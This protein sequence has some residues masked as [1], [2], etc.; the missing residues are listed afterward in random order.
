MRHSIPN[1]KKMSNTFSI[2]T[3]RNFDLR[4]AIEGHGWY[5]LSPFEYHSDK[6][7]LNYVFNMPASGTAAIS[8][9]VLKDRIQITSS[10]CARAEA[11]HAVRHI[12]RMDEDL[13][14]FYSALENGA[15]LGWVRRICAGRLLRSVTVFEDLVKTLCTT[16]CSWSLT[17]KM[18]SNLVELLGN[19]APN[20]QKAFPTPEA[21]AACSFDVFRN[22]I[23]AGY[24]SQYL[25][26]LGQA[27]AEGVIDPE[28]WLYSELPTLDLKKEIMRVKGIGSYAADNLLKLLG[29]YDGL[30]LDSWLRAG[31]YKKHNRGKSCEDR[32]IEKHY[33]KYGAWKGLAIWCDM[34]ESWF[35]KDR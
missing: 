33:A 29:R 27:V 21:I 24:R 28:A 1:I 13:G 15:E 23:R 16:N 26:E 8:I 12:L 4:M 35:S 30:A 14:E 20:G 6:G 7:V 22:D 19:A 18:V 25:V 11:V 32:K 10:G 3:P 31:Y 9:R 2:P 17:K 34:T 5:D